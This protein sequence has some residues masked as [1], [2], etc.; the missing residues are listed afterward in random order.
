MIDGEFSVVRTKLFI[1]AHVTKRNVDTRKTFCYNPTNAV[2]PW[3]NFLVLRREVKIMSGFLLSL[4]ASVIGGLIAN[5][6]SKR[7]F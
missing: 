6:I 2:P 3:L 4:V 1:F 5:Y 7:F